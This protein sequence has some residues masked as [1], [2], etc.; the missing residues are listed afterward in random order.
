MVGAPDVP[1]ASKSSEAGNTCLPVM[2]NATGAFSTEG[3]SPVSK[4]GV[5]GVLI[6]SRGEHCRPRQHGQNVRESDIVA[7]SRSA[8][9]WIRG[10]PTKWVK[11]RATSHTTW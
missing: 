9:G 6:P 1:F 2:G 10:R 5:L 3:L 8:S 7:K 11:L 4:D